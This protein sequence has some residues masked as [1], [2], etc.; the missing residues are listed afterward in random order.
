MFFC[1][2]AG[3]PPARILGASRSWRMAH[4]CI[5]YARLSFSLLFFNFCVNTKCCLFIELHL[6]WPWLK[7]KLNGLPRKLCFKHLI[8]PHH[9]HS[10]S[11][12]LNSE[13]EKSNILLG[14]LWVMGFVWVSLFITGLGWDRE[15]VKGRG[16][17][18]NLNNIRPVLLYKHY[19]L[20]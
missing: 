1:V 8:V 6:E 19:F 10:P 7:D 11:Y 16:W 14:I 4:G 18:R 17:N 20:Y 13:N 3:R 9:C 2:A 5:Y 12:L 15:K